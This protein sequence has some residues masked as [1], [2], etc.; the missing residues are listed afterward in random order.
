MGLS[1][2]I[3]AIASATELL[4]WLP[5]FWWAKIYLS[6]LTILS[7]VASSGILLAAYSTPWTLLVIAFSFYRIFDLLRL[8][9]GRMQL[10]YLYHVTLKT[11][12]VLIACQSVVI[13]AWW[14]TTYWNLPA[15]WQMVSL[16]L[17]QLVLDLALMLST[18]R[19]LRTTREPKISQAYA[20][21]DL[22][23]LTVAIPARNET[24]ELRA[25]LETLLVNDY[26]KLEILVLDDCSQNAK[27][28][29][30]IRSYAHAGVRFV[31][32]S[33]P[34]ANW[35]AKNWGYQKL[36]D[37]ANGELILFCG[38]DI[39]FE[40]DSLRKLISTLL[41]KQKTMLSIM[42]RNVV[43]GPL[44]LIQPMRYAWELALP[45]RLFRRPPVLSTC[46]LIKESLLQSSGGFK[47][48]SRS[49]TPESYFARMS[50][51]D[52]G[53]SFVRSNAVSSHKSFAEQ[54]ATAI[55][56]RY[57][58]LHRRPEMV[59]LVA[60]AEF[61]GLFSPFAVFVISTLNQL[62]LFSLI[63]GLSCLLLTTAYGVVS[64]MTYQKFL[65]QSLVA[66]PVALL[67]DIALLH[68]S[69]WK[70]EFSEVI[71]KDRNVCIPVMRVIPNLPK[72]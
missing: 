57:P 65:I 60:L 70:Y 41:E 38:V 5:G 11:S 4:I 9:K 40:A 3:L 23:N 69:M 43:Q 64:Y 67:V 53:Y 16:L 56:M 47:A 27:T 39:R 54:K 33:E 61:I 14:I 25:C 21:R 8:N 29:E 28:S 15:H 22:P 10:K 19:H 26:P 45:R 46:W 58:Q 66:L 63:S 31:A 51:A 18:L 62:W 32:G 52:D 24:D 2:I 7:L 71:W 1:L 36:S 59:A 13:S 20:D 35:L 55:R 12:L 50:A 48:V 72:L 37:E 42:P 30:I 17:A 68:Y 49:I 6:S 44:A 34:E